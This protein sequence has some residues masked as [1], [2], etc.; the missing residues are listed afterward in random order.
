MSL[1][2]TKRVYN[3]V[4]DAVGGT[5]LI[6]MQKMF[7]DKNVY[8]KAEFMNPGGSIK[9]RIGIYMIAEAE[10]KGIINPGQTIVE[11]SSGNT[12]IGLAL[13]CAIKGYKLVITIPDKMAPEKGLAL[14]AFGAEVIWCPTSVEPEDPRSYY[15]VAE[16]IAKERN[17][18]VPNQ[19][20]NQDNPN[21]HYLTTGPEIWE[22]TEGKVTHVVAGMGTGGT[23]TGIGRYLKEQNKNI[24]LIGADAKGSILKE[25][26]HNADRSYSP[27]SKAVYK[28]EG[29]GEDF[30]P[31]T[32]DLDIIDEI[33][34][35]TDKEGFLTTRETVRNE[36]LMIGGSGGAAVHVA[37][38][39]ASTLQ[40]EDLLVIVVPDGSRP[41][42]NKLFS[43]AWMKE[44]NFL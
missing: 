41:Y 14:E 23:L 4:L 21:A 24:K 32:L 5:P 29:I 3:S 36:G 37:Q 40:A 43:D 38:K 7:P 22:Q 20:H 2:N 27:S 13:A 10:R 35:V 16:R 25:A 31:T 34:T 1:K 17:A 15:S 19:Y 26:Y 6:R 44:N 18:W 39:I 9:D 28:I 42:L 12:G 33:Y 30:I 11:P 8:L